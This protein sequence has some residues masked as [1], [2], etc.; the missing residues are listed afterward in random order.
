MKPNGIKSGVLALLIILCL[1]AV[2]AVAQANRVLILP[3]KMNSPQDATYLQQGILDMLTSRLEWEG[4]VQVISK[5]EAKRAFQQAGG[6]ISEA[7]ARQLGQGLGANYVLFGSVTVAGESVN[8]DAKM[9]DVTGQKAPVTV[10]SQSRGMD[11]VIPE[12]N[13]FA[14]KINSQVFGRSGQP[15]PAPTAPAAGPA[16]G[17]AGPAPAGSQSLPAHRRHPDYLLTGEEGRNLSPLNPNFIAAVG[18]EEKEGQFWRSPSIPIAMVGMDV[19]DVDADGKNEMV[20]A[21]RTTLYVARLENGQFRRLATYEGHARNRFLTVDVADINGDGRAEIFVSNQSD[22]KASSFVFDFRNG[23]L[24]PIVE[25]ANWYYRVV[26]FGTGPTL[27]GQRGGGTDDDLF[28]GRVQVM[29]ASGGSYVPSSQLTVPSE[30]NVFNF[31]IAPLAGEE[32]DYIVS[33]NSSDKLAIFSRSGQDVWTSREYFAGTQNYMV[34]EYGS[35][36]YEGRMLDE[37]KEAKKRIYIPGRILIEDLN[38]DGKKEIIVAINQR[39]DSKYVARW[40]SYDTG[41][42]ISLSFFQ[43]AA[44]EN[45]RSRKLPGYMPDYHIADY[46]ND[47]R[48]ELVVALVIKYGVGIAESRSAIVAYELATPE[49]M[50]AAEQKRQQNW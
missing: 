49:E 50:R 45:W 29:K 1:L 7:K 4:R 15:G 13:A 41:S 8:L 39:S 34:R 16:V 6:D 46:N 2:P 36:E 22:V 43:M 35:Q 18:A 30:F 33:V 44:R 38:D 14:S 5:P 12:V 42:I 26:N 17:S 25:N 11:G 21:S 19:G 10:F 47:G 24:T 48:K 3:F 23:K 20:F 32:K 9:V 28:Y 40:R 31:V 27:L 37:G